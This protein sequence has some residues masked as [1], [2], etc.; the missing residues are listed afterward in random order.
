VFGAFALG[1]VIPHD[2]GMA[3]ELTDRSKTS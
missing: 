2:S 1:A 3:R